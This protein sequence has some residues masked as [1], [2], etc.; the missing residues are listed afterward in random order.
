M[1]FY[2]KIFYSF[3]LLICT[4]LVVWASLRLKHYDIMHVQAE[5]EFDN[6]NDLYT[7]RIVFHSFNSI[8]PAHGRLARLDHN[9]DNA[10][11]ELLV[12]LPKKIYLIKDGFEDRAK[13]KARKEQ[14]TKLISRWDRQRQTQ[15]NL[16]AFS[17]EQIKAEQYVGRHSPDYA[18]Y[19]NLIRLTLRREDKLLNPLHK[20]IQK[21]RQKLR[22]THKYLGKDSS[23]YKKYADELLKLEEQFEKREKTLKKDLRKRTLGAWEGPLFPYKEEGS[24]GEAKAPEKDA[25]DSESGQLAFFKEEPPP[26][27]PG[28]AK[29]YRNI[30]DGSPDYAAISLPGKRRPF[31]QRVD[32]D[33]ENWV[34]E[35]LGS[36]YKSIRNKHIQRYANQYKE[37]LLR[38]YKSNAR[39]ENASVKGDPLCNIEK[40]E[41]LLQEGAQA[42]EQGAQ[43]KETQ[44]QPEKTEDAKDTER[45]QSLYGRIDIYSPQG[46]HYTAIDCNDDGIV[47]TFLVYELDGLYWGAHKELPNTIS[48]FNNMDPEV[49]A[50]IGDL[51]KIQKVGDPEVFSEFKNKEKEIQKSIEDKID[52]A[53]KLSH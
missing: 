21:A 31:F 15:K 33:K 22:L 52:R 34:K 41:T 38:P 39:I 19:E 12:I 25:A 5:I 48:I 42:K 43:E 26:P 29:L 8:D 53:E 7:E 3:V 45:A 47:E 1:S 50:I 16:I 14:Y 13:L 4:P 23:E 10:F 6:V 37:L 32:S 46:T 9:K 30:P 28:M 17:K 49:Q 40:N 18:R 51:I 11:A 44:K 20:R 36:F 2:K 24:N 35:N 27:S